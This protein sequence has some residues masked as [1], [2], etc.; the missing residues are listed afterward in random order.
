MSYLYN[1]RVNIM[2]T[3]KFVEKSYL[4]EEIDNG[5][6]LF[7]KEA[8]KH[9]LASNRLQELFFSE[10]NIDI[11]QNLLAYHVKLQSN[12][13]HNISRQSDNELKIIMKSVYLQYGKNNNN[14]INEQVKELNA[15]V[16]D[17]CIPL[18]LS[19]IEQY[20]VFK[21]DVSTLPV[22][23]DN[24]KYTSSTGTRTNPDYIF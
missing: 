10:K 18:I 17:F 20:L 9:I 16:L 23:L 13:R 11:I 6:K 5:N 2:G 15:Y 1:G 4:Y 21:K 3:G 12:N 24:P 8:V 14:N 19:N 7:K 22:P